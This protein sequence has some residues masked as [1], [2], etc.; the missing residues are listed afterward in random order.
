MPNKFKKPCAYPGCPA[1]TVNRYCK[2]HERMVGKAMDKER[3][4]S[5]A[6]GYTA[7]WQRR[8]REYLRE[9]PL[10]RHCQNKG[11][12]IPADL[13]DHIIPHKG[14]MNLFWDETNWQ[15][16]CTECHNRKTMNESIAKRTIINEVK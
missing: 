11:K 10:C 5:N 3:P 16:L 13:I 15:P 8:R 7:T 4:S 14:D 6:R 2:K 12:L 9:N 1:L